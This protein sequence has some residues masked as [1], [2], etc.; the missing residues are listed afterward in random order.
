MRNQIFSAAAAVCMVASTG[1]FSFEHKSN[2]TGPV[3][4]RNDGVRG[5]MDFRQHHPVAECLR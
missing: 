1:C 4:D 2:I 5:R 3:G